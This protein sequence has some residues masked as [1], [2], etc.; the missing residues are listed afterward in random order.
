MRTPRYALLLTLL[1]AAIATQRVVSSVSTSP[2]SPDRARADLTL[3]A[4][5]LARRFSR[6]DQP[7]ALHSLLISTRLTLRRL[8]LSVTRLLSVHVP[9]LAIN[10]FQ[11]RLPPPQLA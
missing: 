6:E 9:P 2:L 5:N 3:V 8:L 1:V 4:R 11:F 10:P 7:R